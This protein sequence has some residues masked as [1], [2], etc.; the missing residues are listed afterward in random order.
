[1][2]DILLHVNDEG[3]GVELVRFLRT[4]DFVEIESANN[5]VV[6]QRQSSSLKCLQGMWKN[7]DVSLE[8]I[9]KK[10]WRGVE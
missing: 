8:K 3:K 6:L 4:L 7:K 9:R 5:Q 2:T 10:A 1:M